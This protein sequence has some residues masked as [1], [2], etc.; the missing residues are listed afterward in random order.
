MTTRTLFLV[1]CLITVGCCLEHMVAHFVSTEFKFLTLMLKAH[2]QLPLLEGCL[3]FLLIFF[4]FTWLP[5]LACYNQLL[6]LH[7]ELADYHSVPPAFSLPLHV[8]CLLEQ[9]SCNCE[10]IKVMLYSA[11]LLER[12]YLYILFMYLVIFV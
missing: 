3:H 12:L 10:P 1:M 11:Y 5:C 2:W 6:F 8:C 4:L 7:I 9:L